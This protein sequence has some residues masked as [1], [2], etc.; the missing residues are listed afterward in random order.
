MSSAFTKKY[1]LMYKEIFIIYSDLDQLD[2][3]QKDSKLAYK[4]F[5]Q[6]TQEIFILELIHR[7]VVCVFEV[8]HKY[9][10]TKMLV[11]SY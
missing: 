9:C 10:F 3:L 6:I 2:I 7:L 5:I 1:V 8:I 4:Q 11:F